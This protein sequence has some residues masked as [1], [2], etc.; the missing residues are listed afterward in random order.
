MNLTKIRKAGE[1]IERAHRE[2]E[3]NQEWRNFKDNKDIIE[4]GDH[5]DKRKFWLHREPNWGIKPKGG[6]K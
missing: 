6:K 2:R 1:E 3:S 5:D 4:A